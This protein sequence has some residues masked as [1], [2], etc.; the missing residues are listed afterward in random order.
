MK[1]TPL[2]FDPPPSAIVVALRSYFDRL[3][4]GPLPESVVSSVAAAK[5]R[6]AQRGAATALRD[7]TARFKLNP[8][9]S[10][11]TRRA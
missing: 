3:L 10:A 9:E 1:R 11:R 4:A 6:A 2:V 5:V 8:N 7:G